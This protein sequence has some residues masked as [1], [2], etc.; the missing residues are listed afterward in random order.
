MSSRLRWR[1]RLG[2]SWEQLPNPS[3]RGL[4]V[5]LCE[6][7]DAKGQIPPN[8]GGGVRTGIRPGFP[9]TNAQH[10]PVWMRALAERATGIQSPFPMLHAEHGLVRARP[11]G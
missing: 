7:R 4:G 8:L 2:L 6:I 5:D 11:R 3:N 9:T 1:R 10:R